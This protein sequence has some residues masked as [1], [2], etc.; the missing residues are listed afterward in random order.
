[1]KKI[2][3]SLIL[4]SVLFTSCNS[5]IV[6]PTI[7]KMSKELVITKLSNGEKEVEFVGM[8]HVARPQFYNAAVDIITKAK[9][10]NAVLFYE[11]IDYNINDTLTLRKTQKIVGFIPTVKNYT[12][13]TEKILKKGVLEVQDN[14]KFLNIVNDKDFRVDYTP[15]RFVKEYEEKFGEVVLTKEDLSLCLEEMND[16][17][18]PEKKVNV[19]LLDHRNQFLA[20]QVNISKFKKI[21]II[22]G[23]A[24]LSGFTE[25]LKRID[26]NWKTID[27]QTIKF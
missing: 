21:I 5:L 14:N 24:H 1:M 27:K 26:K 3:L 13:I 25:E 17:K 23:K 4:F 7:R 22:Y 19:I 20:E 6:R 2:F 16:N 18:E 8:V 11:L 10:N 15:Q 9:E 12:K